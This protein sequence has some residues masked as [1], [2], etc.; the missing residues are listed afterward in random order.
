MKE[1]AVAGLAQH[2]PAGLAA[3]AA[4]VLL[5]LLLGQ[6]VE[7]VRYTMAVLQ[8]PYQIDYDEGVNLHAAWLLSQG[9]PIYTPLD[10]NYFVS[11]PYTPLYYLLA[12]LPLIGREPA[13][14]GG[15]LISLFATIGIALLVGEMVRQAGR[16]WPAGI[17]SALFLLALAPMQVWGLL[18]KQDML[19]ILFTVG[20]LYV[21]QRWGERR[22]A[23]YWAVPLFALAFFTKQ[24]A[25]V[26]PPVATLYLL[27]HDLRTT[28]GG[29]RTWPAWRRATGFGLASAAAIVIP[30]LLLQFLFLPNLYLH[31]F[32]YQQLPWSLERLLKNL[33]KLAQNYP[34]LLGV[35][36]FGAGYLLW[37]RRGLLGPLYLL[38]ATVTVLIANGIE[39]GN[40]NLLLDI[41][42]PLALLM[43]TLLGELWAR[44]R[45]WPAAAMLLLAL[46]VL[47]WQALHLAGPTL[48]Y[49]GLP[50]EELTSR[51]AEIERLLQSTPGPILSENIGVL[52]RTG[53]EVE[54]DDPST[55]SPLARAGIWDDRILADKISSRYYRLILLSYDITNLDKAIRW[56]PQVFQAMKT[57]YELLYPD[58]LFIYR[59][60]SGRP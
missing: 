1:R 42:P 31:V 21:V 30:F 59:P 19:A 27:V 47:I 53:H 55:F 48:W 34:Y 24:T 22:R 54:Y 16:S 56:S 20:G 44:R 29:W 40:Y 5:A 8:F 33:T 37:Q 23:F 18:Y 35:S 50:N 7:F 3:I 60:R 26:G 6:C 11:A 13:F 28:P 51:Y 25:L 38:G 58:A 10:P 43:G 52:L 45:R 41:F 57:H 49:R 36:L 14:E 2:L 46:L 17:L 4:A 12:A 15:R 9:K 39:G 32:G